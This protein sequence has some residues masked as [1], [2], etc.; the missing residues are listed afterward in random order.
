MADEPGRNRPNHF[1]AARTLIELGR[2]DEAEQELRRGIAEDPG[3]G[4]AYAVL[5]H[6]LIRRKALDE[7]L[8]A[9]NR[10][11]QL[12]PEAAAVWG[13]RA[14]VLSRLKRH[15]EALA[16]A[17]RSLALDASAPEAFLIRARVNLHAGMRDGALEDV[18]RALAID[19]AH[20]D[21]HALRAQLLTLMGRS[22]EA[23]QASSALLGTAPTSS[24]A[25]TVAGWQHLHAGRRPEAMER[26]REA[27]RLSPLNTSARTGL[28]ETLR[29]G[30]PLYAVVQKLLLWHVRAMTARRARFALPAIA[31]VFG[32]ARAWP[33]SRP[34][35]LPLIIAGVALFL[36]T[37]VLAR[38]L[39]NCVLASSPEDRHLLTPDERHEARLVL[40]VL[41]S[42]VG[43][44]AVWV[45]TS[46]PVWAYAAVSTSLISLVVAEVYRSEGRRRRILA[47]AGVAA[48]VSMTAGLVLVLLGVGR[49]ANGLPRGMSAVMMFAPIVVAF[50]PRWAGTRSR[51]RIGLRGAR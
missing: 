11:A 46:D 16:D 1:A 45:A 25:H 35:L 19:P 34:F 39:A 27:L 47:T 28:M 23:G 17:D 30:N 33:A 3:N 51:P 22:Q 49:P 31:A 15:K 32:V 36:M 29:A 26:F 24:Q 42:A 4:V 18:E 43:L 20:E 48:L 2:H 41:A 21:A 44:A 40:A 12:S 7:A 37:V 9:C 10:G 8:D 6:C 38:P 5:A 50:G 14:Q 13:V